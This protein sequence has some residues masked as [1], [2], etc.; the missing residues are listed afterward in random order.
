MQELCRAATPCLNTPV[1][2]LFSSPY[3]IS[4]I[5]GRRIAMKCGWPR[6]SV[7]SCSSRDQ[8]R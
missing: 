7:N 1:R 3:V 6:R 5:T 4:H 8:G 2:E